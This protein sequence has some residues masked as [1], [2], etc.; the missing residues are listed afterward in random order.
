[1]CDKVLDDNKCIVP[2]VLFFKI[3]AIVS[4]ETEK[5][6]GVGRDNINDNAK[7]L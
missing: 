6:A 3:M 4:A 1:M 2:V 7:N 5:T